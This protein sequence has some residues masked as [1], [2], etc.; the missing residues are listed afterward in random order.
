M[1]KPPRHGFENLLNWHC[2]RSGDVDGVKTMATVDPV[3][4]IGFGPPH[5]CFGSV[6][7][8]QKKVGRHLAVM[9][10]GEIVFFWH[11]LSFLPQ[12]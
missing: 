12:H 3:L 5:A 1:F 6:W 11:L 8:L 9:W 4:K 2:V 7:S 10:H